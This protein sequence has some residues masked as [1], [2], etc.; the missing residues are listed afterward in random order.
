MKVTSR[1]LSVVLAAA[2]YVGLG[3]SGAAMLGLAG[4]SAVHAAVVSN[5][6]VR[7]NKRVDAATIRDYL[8]IKPGHPF[9]AGDIDA[10]TKRLFSTGLFSDVRINQV[11]G[12]LVIQVAEY[13]VVNQ[14]V[15]VGNKKIK[16]ADLANGVRLKPQSPFSN[17]ILDGDIKRIKDAYQH[18]GRNDVT[19]TPQVIDLG[20][21]RVNV[22][23]HIAEGGRTKIA[24]INFIG[25]KAFSDRRLSD[26]ISTKRSNFLSF[27][28]RNDI[29][30]A[31]KLRTDEEA[32]RRFYYNHGYADFRVVSSS[33]ELNDATNEYTI[34]ITVDEGA[35]YRFGDIAVE[36]NIQNVDANSL[37]PLLKT[38]QGDIYSAK[39]VED[40]I[41]ALTDRMAGQGYAFAQVTPRGD[42]NFQNR[43]IAVT[44]AIDEGP[45]TYIQRI[46]IRGNTR[47]RD[48]VI[49]REFDI[50]E[51]DAF[52]QVLIQKAKKRLEDLDYFS[53]VNITT[54]PGSE[55]DQVILI[56][57]VVEKSTGQFSIGAGYSTG[58][59]SS[60]GKGISLQGSIAERNF[61]GRG[62]YIRI[63]AGGGL[64]GSRDYALSFTEP[65]FL[66]RRIS[67]G[68][69]I[70][71]STRTYDR[72]D[73][74]MTGGTIRFGLPITDALS[75]QFAYNLVNES[76]D[77]A[78]CGS[79]KDG[80]L[81]DCKLSQ[82]IRDAIA[83]SPWL[84][85]SVSGSII[86]NTIDDLKN[87]ANGLYANFTTEYAGIG[88][89]ANFVKFTARASYYK[90]IS[91]QMDLV[92]LIS[93]GA[94]YI[95]E[96]G[97]GVRIFD[98]FES[99][100]RIIRGFDFNG[101][102][103]YDS[104]TGDHLGGT[105]YF[106]ATAELQFP[107]PAVPESFGLKGAVFADAATLYGNNL[108]DPCTDGSGNKTGGDCMA[109]QGMAW[110]ASAGVSLLWA[111]PFGPLRLDYAIP[112]LKQKGDKVQNFN[113]GVSTQF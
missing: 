103:P 105:T 72:Y 104:S 89:D 30:D 61:L 88:G 37:K 102:G 90:T 65:Y 75:T 26:V 98:L 68:F 20:Q 112:F 106:N 79:A 69:D 9:D 35:L 29:Y 63:S 33:A 66:G 91:E 47:T 2:L 81:G 21:D 41:V 94:G 46:E 97:D 11:G 34:N 14:V 64:D 108:S 80:T 42:R 4:V 1:I 85:S 10:A 24:A 39:N 113:F 95:H 59:T 28:L 57:D 62:Q 78:R 74:Q 40:S 45:H 23:F 17:A 43:T 110:R 32:L 101:I 107:L 48:Y 18:I 54:A 12:T 55:P 7:G 15:F 38:R 111:S 87:P 5:I 93:G 77:Y 67:A 109:G 6:E 73:S 31:D 58:E 76:Y 51:G 83:K 27:V 96:F 86:Y 36:S 99:N 84:K 71:R 82:V 13:P 19:V 49:R 92:A 16:D 60:S 44:Y 100:D 22:V 56:V 3:F 53:S 50:S 70:Y 25:N 8:S 52:N